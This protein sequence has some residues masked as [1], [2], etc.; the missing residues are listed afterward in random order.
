[1]V[2]D[3]IWKDIEGYEG[4]YQVSNLGR[5][6]SLYGKGRILKQSN[7]TVYPHV[8]LSK[9]GQSTTFSVHRLVG[10]AFVPNPENKPE[11]NHK[12]GDKNN[13]VASNLE[14]ITA[15]ENQKHSVSIGL[16]ASGEQVKNHKLSAKDVYEIR[17]LYVPNKRG[18][19]CRAL[20]KKYGVNSGTIWDIVNDKYWKWT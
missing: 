9:N 17:S 4:L 18:H 6:Q 10:L 12:D 13:N 3:E 16:K 7:S 15:S 11:I 8:S 14:W 2:F 20:G 5:V 19:G 1:M